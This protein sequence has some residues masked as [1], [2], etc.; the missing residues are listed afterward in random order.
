MVRRFL[1]SWL[2]PSRQAPIE[3][4][5]E[6]GLPQLVWFAAPARRQG[7]VIGQDRQ[8]EATD[9]PDGASVFLVTGEVALG[10][11]MNRLAISTF[12]RGG[13]HRDEGA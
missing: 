4:N 9:L 11:A 10:I 6:P 3:C 8:R 13:F 2:E 1:E 7:S 5:R 12:W